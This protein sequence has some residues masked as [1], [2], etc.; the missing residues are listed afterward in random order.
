MS[1]A[2]LFHGTSIHCLLSILSDGVMRADLGQDD[3]PDGVSMSTSSEVAR[4]FAVQAEEF[5]AYREGFPD[6]GDPCQGAVL[7]FD[8]QRV[9]ERAGLRRVL[10]D[11]VSVEAEMR[12]TGSF[13]TEGAL[14]G[15]EIAEEDIDWYREVAVD[16]DEPLLALLNELATHPARIS[17]AS[18]N[19]SP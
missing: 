9:E 14:I 1:G 19:P 4:I 13:A 7:H 10:W 16:I 17:M 11:G 6:R 5:A 12:S 15:F 8:R 18:S 2:H 3:H